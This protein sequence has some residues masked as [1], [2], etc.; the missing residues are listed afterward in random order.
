MKTESTYQFH[1][2]SVAPTEVLLTLSLAQMHL[3]HDGYDCDEALVD[4]LIGSAT[5]WI[6]RQYDLALLTQ[7]VVEYHRGFPCSNDKALLLRTS[8][9]ASVTRLKYLDSNG[10]EQTLSADDY[11]LMQ[12]PRYAY[13]VLKP[14]KTWPA[15]YD[16]ALP[17]RATVVA[18]YGAAP[19]AV[20]EPIRNA[21]L[22]LLT[23]LYQQRENPQI[24]LGGSAV[25]AL[26]RPFERNHVV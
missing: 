26:L 18:G 13:L 8:P 15:T 5:G 4:L 7:T 25:Q 11:E 10:A 9:V 3:R 16:H 23:Q 22:L 20:P 17:V 14:T 19:T 24:E 12:G 2:V 1:A 21:A 6:E